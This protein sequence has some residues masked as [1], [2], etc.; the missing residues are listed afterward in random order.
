MCEFFGI[1]FAT[2]VI[3]TSPKGSMNA[4]SPIGFFLPKILAAAASVIT[5]VLGLANAVTALP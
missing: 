3:I 5:I 4:S 1:S 2:P